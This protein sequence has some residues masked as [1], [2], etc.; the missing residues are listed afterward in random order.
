M[1]YQIAYLNVYGNAGVLA[2]ELQTIL[3]GAEMVDLSGNQEISYSSD[4][5]LLVFEI[6][7]DAIPLKIMD[8]LENLEGKTVLCIV[9]CSMALLESKDMEGC[10]YQTV[11]DSIYAALKNLKKFLA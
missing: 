9:T 6:T 10:R 4:V 3:A 2:D 1:D 7:R 11:Q 8:V 5:Y